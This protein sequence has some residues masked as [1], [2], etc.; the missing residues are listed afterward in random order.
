MRLIAT[1]SMVSSF[2]AWGQSPWPG[3]RAVD[4]NLLTPLDVQLQTD[5]SGAHWDPA[6]QRLWVTRPTRSWALDRT[7]AGFV[8]RGSWPFGDEGI[9]A[10]AYG[11]REDTQGEVLWLLESPAR[12][13]HVVAV[14][15]G[16]SFQTK[17]VWAL[18]PLQ[19]ATNGGQ[20][21]EGLAF[22]P[23]G[24][25]RDGGFVDAQG[26]PRVSTRGQGG[27]VFV[28][29]QNG[30]DV[31]VFDLG[32]DGGFD[33]VGRYKTSGTE[34]SGLE[35]DRLRNVLYVSHNEGANTLELVA[36]SSTVIG[37][38]RQFVTLTKYTAPS[39][40]NLEGFAIEPGDGSRSC[41]YTEDHENGDSVSE[42][43][44]SLQWYPGCAVEAPRPVHVDAG[45]DAGV[46]DGGAEDAG[47]L[48]VEPRDAGVGSMEPGAAP[49]GCGCSAVEP[50]LMMAA[51]W[52]Q[53]RRR[54]FT[55]ARVPFE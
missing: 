51:L 27:L 34:S 55:L 15:D 26:Q 44:R 42:R 3:T 25:L 19:L 35:H 2:L 18:T 8:V 7:D 12:V 32:A 33:T 38:N 6:A 28:A 39:S 45:T 53:L 37:S 1:I 20:G 16:G 29:H 11:A 30:G 54:T 24:C 46:V 40:T 50:L 10:T 5:L 47:Q 13:H 31:F 41:W 22:V 36:L 4:A 9:S 23:D 14:F 17:T 52:A 49:Q 48:P 43:A 21:P